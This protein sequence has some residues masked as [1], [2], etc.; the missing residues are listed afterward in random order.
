MLEL[1]ITYTNFR[2]LKKKSFLKRTFYY[3][4]TRIALKK[5]DLYS[6][7]SKEDKAFLD[8]TFK[9]IEISK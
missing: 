2:I 6:V 5:A 4:L 7:T 9:L 8:Q 3:Q 1:V